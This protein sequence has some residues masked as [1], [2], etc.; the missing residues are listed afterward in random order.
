MDPV[1]LHDHARLDADLFARLERRLS[2]HE[3]LED[4][5]RFCRTQDT[6]IA[7]VVTQDEFTFD[8]LVPYGTLWL[9]YDTT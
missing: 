1:Q 7:D 9:A 4:V 3:A 8:V 2:R 5:L 6:D